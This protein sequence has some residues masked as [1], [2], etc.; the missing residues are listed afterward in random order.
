VPERNDHIEVVS[1]AFDN[2]SMQEEKRE[3]EKIE[4]RDFYYD[5][6]YKVGYGLAILAALFIG[7]KIFKKAMRFLKSLALPAGARGDLTGV[8]QIID[9]RAPA[10][11]PERRKARLSDQMVQV[12]KER[13]D[14][15]ARVIKTMMVD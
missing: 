1:V 2:T 11:I 12:A 13:P 3:L 7:L 5:I 4:K 14:E 10:I 9:E 6:A 15:M 8:S